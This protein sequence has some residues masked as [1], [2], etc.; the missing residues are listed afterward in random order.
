VDKHPEIERILDGYRRHRWRSKPV[1]AIHSLLNQEPKSTPLFISRL[2]KVGDEYAGQ[3]LTAAEEHLS[4]EDYSPLID[5]AIRLLTTA[6]HPMARDFIEDAFLRRGVPLRGHLKELFLADH[7]FKHIYGYM[8]WRD[9]GAEQ[10]PYLAG[11]IDDP[12][13]RERAIGALLE[14][15]LP[16][17]FVLI[18]SETEGIRFRAVGFS[19]EGKG[20]RQLFAPQAYHLQFDWGEWGRDKNE[21]WQEVEVRPYRFGGVVEGQYCATCGDTLHHLLTFPAFE[22]LPDICSL[23][24]LTLATCNHCLGWE[25]LVI[26]LQHNES[27]L[28]ESKPPLEPATPEFCY[29][30]FEETTVALTPVPDRYRWQEWGSPIANTYRIGGHPAWI[31]KPEYPTCPSCSQVMP[32]LMELDSEIP[33]V[34]PNPENLGSMEWGSGGIAYFFWCDA[35]RISAGMWQCT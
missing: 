10:V 13:R 24:S 25:P 27:G 29:A 22:Y 33:F 5:E 4:P 16:E 1:E 30:P 7:Y 18:P 35:C 6:E 23:P 12:E 31:Q 17:A 15:R 9:G 28:P 32:F 2:M 34:W 26:F 19:C 20:V 3:M 8:A 21:T 14:L 11:F